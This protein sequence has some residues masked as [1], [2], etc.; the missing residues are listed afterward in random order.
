M[1]KYLILMFIVFTYNG[2]V[3]QK[4]IEVGTKISL[5]IPKFVNGGI[6][7]I[8]TSKYTRVRPAFGI[9]TKYHFHKNF[10]LEYDLGLS[11]EGGGYEKR[12]TN[13]TFLKNSLFIGVSSS[14]Y[15]TNSFN[16]KL[17]FNHNL[18]LSATMKD[19]FYDAET[20]VSEYFKRSSN[21]IPFAFGYVRKIG[22]GYAIK[23]NAHFQLFASPLSELKHISFT[24]KLARL[25]LGISK[26]IK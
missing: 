19:E 10:F 2:I 6:F 1:K 11:W 8:T 7:D 16:F 23:A 22:E 18:L 5:Q 3:A 9:Y 25:E 24:Q 14:T 4:K 21:S 15:K 12:E 26:Y 13:L 17:G 20:D